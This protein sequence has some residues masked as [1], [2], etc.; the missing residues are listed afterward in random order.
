MYDLI[1]DFRNHY[2]RTEA[3]KPLVSHSGFA[4]LNRDSQ[5]GTQKDEETQKG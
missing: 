2:R 3:L 1:E 4:T 5:E